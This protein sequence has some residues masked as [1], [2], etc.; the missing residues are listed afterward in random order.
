MCLLRILTNKYSINLIDLQPHIGCDCRC[1]KTGSILTCIHLKCMTFLQMY[2][3]LHIPAF[4]QLPPS[5]RVFVL[6][7]AMFSS[8]AIIIHYKGLQSTVT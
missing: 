1:E 2:N 7:S 4:Q 6:Y 3:S 8:P 5:C